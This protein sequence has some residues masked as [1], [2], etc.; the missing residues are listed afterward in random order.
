MTIPKT[1]LRNTNIIMCERELLMNG[2]KHMMTTYVDP[3]DLLT[4][5]PCRDVMTLL[6]VS[7]ITLLHQCIKGLK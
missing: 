6:K 2:D 7:S 1:T 4:I 3:T 5:T